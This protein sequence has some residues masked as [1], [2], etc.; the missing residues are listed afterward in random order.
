MRR[1]KKSS[2]F[3]TD[4]IR[5]RVGDF[6]LDNESIYYLGDSIGQIL[7]GAKILIG[8]DTRGS[9][10]NIKKLIAAGI[11][12]RAGIFDCGVVSTPGVSFI[13][14][15][16]DSDYGIMITASHNPYSDNGIKIF[17]GS[18]EKISRGIEQDIEDIFF[19]KYGSGR[20][21]SSNEPINI[22]KIKNKNIYKDFLVEEAARLKGEKLKVLIDCAH[23]AVYEIAPAV[24]K[25]AGIKTKVIN[26]SPNGCNI[27]LSSGSTNPHILSKNVVEHEAD[28]GIAFDGDGDRVIFADN[29]GNILDGDHSLYAISTYLFETN[30]NFNK[31]VVGTVIGNL[32]LEK[33]LSEKGIKYIRSQVGDYNVYCEMK[34]VNAAVGG[35]QSGHTILRFLQ[36][37]GDG[38]L[39]AVYFL[40]ALSYF[41]LKPDDLINRLPLFPQITKNIKIREKKELDKWEKLQQMIEGFNNKHGKN[42]RIIIRYSGTEPKIR[43]MM[44]SEH[45]SVIR[46]N[47]GNFENLIKSEIG[48]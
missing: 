5:G 35:E 20:E 40:K 11:S 3:G 7:K 34:R 2:L 37:T 47:L 43:I 9:G 16:S 17:N 22:N 18:G 8:R 38:I 15:H 13:T 25:E 21:K 24:F 42:S 31:I 29:K 30:K 10:E 45:N 44:E 23:G 39:T 32:G 19:S 36:P 41:N 12:N 26:A 4:G 27:N 1:I 6:P 46:E 48:G 14:G 28:I 33:A